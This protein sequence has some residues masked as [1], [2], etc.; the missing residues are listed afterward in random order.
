MSEEIENYMV[1]LKNSTID[2]EA[3]VEKCL[4]LGWEPIGGIAIN[5]IHD[6]EGCRAVFYQAMV[7][8]KAPF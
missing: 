2:I 4:V 5:H 7:K 1:V 6:E 3:E 8:Y